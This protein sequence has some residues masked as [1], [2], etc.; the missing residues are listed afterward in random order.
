MNRGNRRSDIF[1]D[2][3]DFQVYLTILRQAME[4]YEYVLYSYCLM[5][6][7][8]HMQIETKDVEIWKIMRYINLSYTK[9]FRKSSVVFSF[10][11]VPGTTELCR[12]ENYIKIRPPDS[13]DLKI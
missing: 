6:N 11:R 7:H 10:V 4:K 13:R 1:K 9:Y 2:E 5:T 8:I 12:I 3:E